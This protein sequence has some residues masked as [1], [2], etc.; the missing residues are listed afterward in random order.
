M[1]IPRFVQM[2][3]RA[4]V[5]VARAV[6]DRVRAARVQRR[7]SLGAD[8]PVLTV[9]DLGYGGYQLPERLL[10]ERSVVLSAGAGT[11]VEFETCLVDR[12]GCRV[13]LVDPVPSSAAYVAEALAY[14]PRV[15]F[16]PLALWSADCELTFHEPVRA[17][18]VS[19][20]ATNMH[21]TPPVFTCG[22][23]S[24]A[25]LADEYHWP[26]I[27]LLKVS[28]EGSE[29]EIL[30]HVVDA[31]VTVGAL[32][33]E[34]AQPTD[35]AKVMA[36]IGELDSAGYALVAHSLRPRN[37]KMTFAAREPASTLR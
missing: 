23:R 28:A 2:L 22:A 26:R 7:L 4:S 13:L 12:Y 1:T 21:G 6:D 10:S 3:A 34:F 36:T 33:V 29:F 37:W 19:H 20:S 8:V 17:G 27:D 5:R 25:S 16:R 14:E 35:P 31:R 30:R 32:C 15:E 9:G 18:F 11:D 24:V